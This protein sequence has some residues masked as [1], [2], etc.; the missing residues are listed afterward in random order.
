MMM[1]FDPAKDAKGRIT[2][3]LSREVIDTFR[4]LSSLR[5]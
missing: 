2:I 5:R 1:T 3:H 4:R